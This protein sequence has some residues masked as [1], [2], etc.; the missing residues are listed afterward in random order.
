MKRFKHIL[1]FA[2]FRT[3]ADLLVVVCIFWHFITLFTELCSKKNCLISDQS[4]SDVWSP[5]RC[6]CLCFWCWVLLISRSLE[7]C[8]ILFFWDCLRSLE[9]CCFVLRFSLFTICF[10]PYRPYLFWDCLRCVQR[11]FS[12][13]LDYVIIWKHVYMLYND[14]ALIVLEATVMLDFLGCFFFFINAVCV[15]QFCLF[16]FLFH[17]WPNVWFRSNPSWR[18]LVQETLQGAAS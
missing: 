12:Y 7:F 11:V 18:D 5:H 8:F 10:C 17:R 6:Y 4:L 3:L 16:L 9:M 13:F 2:Y 1:C 15:F 14:Y